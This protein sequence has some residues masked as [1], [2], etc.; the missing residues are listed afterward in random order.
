M[1]VSSIKERKKPS[2]L[3][4]LLN[5]YIVLTIVTKHTIL[6]STS[7][8]RYDTT[9]NSVNVIKHYELKHSKHESQFSNP[10]ITLFSTSVHH[11]GDVVIIYPRNIERQEKDISRRRKEKRERIRDRPALFVRTIQVRACNDRTHLGAV[12]GHFW[13][14]ISICRTKFIFMLHNY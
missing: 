13:A 7:N 3:L 10:E 4:N 2:A 5:I 9:C 1:I 14:N 8:K 12:R 6:Q 11:Y